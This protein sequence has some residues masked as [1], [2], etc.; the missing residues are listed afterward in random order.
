[1]QKHPSPAMIDVDAA[2]DIALAQVMPLSDPEEVTLAAASGRIAAGDVLSVTSMPFFTC[3]AMDGFALSSSTTGSGVLRLPVAGT[4]AAGAGAA[5]PLRPGTAARI[6]TGA[7]LPEGADAVLPVEETREEDG[8]VVLSRRPQPGENVR[9]AGSDQPMG[10]R[11]IA[12]GQRI[13][14]HHIGLL[15]ANGLAR[16]SVVRRPRI[17]VLSTGDELARGARGEGQIHDAN[18]PMLLALAEAAGAEAVDGGVLSDDLDG[19]AKSLTELAET[20]DLVVTSGGA[21]MGGLDLLRPAVAAAGGEIAAWRVAVKPGKPVMFGKVRQTGFTG[22]PGNPFAAFVGFHLFVAAQIDRLTG[23]APTAFAQA[24]ARAEFSW[25]RSP[26]RL[27]VFP[28]RCLGADGSGPVRLERLG[29][30]VSGTL[31]PLA[32]ADGLA[33]VPADCGEVIPGQRLDWHPFCG[34]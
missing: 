6:Y 22:L 15:A 3:S 5:A 28:V 18:R 26:G 8:H 32:E 19:I 16:L 4:I 7:A 11:L 25:R 24:S 20:A 12:K 2:R 10:A 30:G 17:A 29:Q 23:R 14:P 31:F 27:E 33:V 9:L 34:R 21:S 1:M 13:L